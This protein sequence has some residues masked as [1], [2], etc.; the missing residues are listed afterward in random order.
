MLLS[1]YD[2]QHMQFGG[3]FHLKCPMSLWGTYTFF[4]W[5]TTHWGRKLLN[6]AASVSRLQKRYRTFLLPPFHWCVWSELLQSN[7]DNAL[8][9]RG[10]MILNHPVI[11]IHISLGT[12][13]I[14]QSFGT[15]PLRRIKV[16]ASAY[17]IYTDNWDGMEKVIRRAC[18]RK[19]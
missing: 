10:P 6:L 1:I 12:I 13:T 5:L 16:L 4:A 7:V 15:N 3:S 8:K 18:V 19:F 9:N 17:T 14:L 11:Q 2:M